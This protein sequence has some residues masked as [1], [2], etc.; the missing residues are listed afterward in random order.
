ME[1]LYCN[2]QVYCD[3]EVYCSRQQIVLQLSSAV[4]K[5]LL[6]DAYCI[7]TNSNSQQSTVNS[8]FGKKKILK[9]KIK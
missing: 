1:K 4:G 6:Q 9:N 7:V 3:Q 8:K 5:L 2:T